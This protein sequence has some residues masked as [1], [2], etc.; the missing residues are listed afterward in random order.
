M[1][2]PLRGGSTRLAGKAGQAPDTKRVE[3]PGKGRV[4]PKIAAQ[5]TCNQAGPK[6]PDKRNSKA[7]PRSVD[8]GDQRKQA[9]PEVPRR[10]TR[11]SDHP[12]REIRTIV[13]FQAPT[14]PGR[15][16]KSQVPIVQ[17]LE[18]DRYALRGRAVDSLN[19]RGNGRNSS[20]G[21]DETVKKALEFRS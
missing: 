9:S 4:T 21:V 19:L 6:L 12:S 13:S 2:K 8:P 5:E 1:N 15:L 17:N 18:Y 20:A 11:H 7:Q 14:S 16:T 3:R 10:E